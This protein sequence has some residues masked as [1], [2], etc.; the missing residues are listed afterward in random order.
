[1]LGGIK[2][3]KGTED[4]LRAALEVVPAHPRLLV[5]IAGSDFRDGS[6]ERRAYYGR[7][8]EVI[9]SLRASRSIRMVGEIPNPLELIAASDIV[10]SPSPES[11]FPR[12]VIEAWR[13]RKPVIAASTAHIHDLVTQ[14]VNGL[15]VPPG[16]PH[17]LAQAIVRLLDDPALGERLAQEG[18]TKAESDFDAE[19]NVDVIVDRCNTCLLPEN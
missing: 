15:I 7:C 4:V 2:Q 19:R 6:L 17:R 14:E 3:I 18:K 16:D 11:H 13:L 9:A 5:V 1:M 12:P 8:M 10:V